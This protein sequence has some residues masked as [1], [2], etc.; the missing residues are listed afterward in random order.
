MRFGGG[1]LLTTASNSEPSD[2]IVRA[3]KLVRFDDEICDSSLALD[4]VP[5]PRSES[6]GT[7][8]AKKKVYFRDSLRFNGQ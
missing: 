7:V 6:L 5:G 1:R 4:F 8:V 3:E 2:M